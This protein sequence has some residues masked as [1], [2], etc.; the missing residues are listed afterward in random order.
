MLLLPGHKPK[1]IARQQEVKYN[2]FT[3]ALYISRGSNHVEVGKD[4]FFLSQR[5]PPC[6]LHQN[7]N[8]M[9][10]HLTIYYLAG[11]NPYLPL[12]V[13]TFFFGKLQVYT[14]LMPLYRL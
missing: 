1:P 14:L 8:I 4:D 10:F 3:V 6:L 12:Q 5:D 11:S 2:I 13:Y 9:E 7:V